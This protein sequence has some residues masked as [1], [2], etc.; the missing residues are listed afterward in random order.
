MHRH[1]PGG[2]RRGDLTTIYFLLE[3]GPG[4][5]WHR[6]TDA[7]EVWCYHSG[8][9][10]SLLLSGPDVAEDVTEVVLGPDVLAGQSPQAVVP[11]GEWQSARSQGAWTLVTCVVAPAFTFE[12]FEMHGAE[13]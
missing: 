3:A 2:G 7:E 5:A 10:L 11:R 6:V 13:E 9:P 4:S 8:A 1:D 12:S